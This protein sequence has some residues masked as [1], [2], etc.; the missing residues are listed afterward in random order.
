MPPSTYDRYVVVIPLLTW[1]ISLFLPTV[2][3]SKNDWFF[4]GQS[5]GF[6]AALMSF[7]ALLF[8][9]LAF[10][11]KPTDTSAIVYAY[12]GSLWVANVLMLAAPFLVSAIQRRRRFAFVVM[13]WIW[14]LLAL[15]LAFLSR[16]SS[17]AESLEFG[18]F[19]WLF[20]LFTMALLMTGLYAQAPRVPFEANRQRR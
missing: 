17:D 16:K 13:L 15:P 2:T 1:A 10:G 8:W 12:I 3:C 18:Y 11:M 20:S 4:P 14:F 9:M 5:P 7:L 6:L 19:V